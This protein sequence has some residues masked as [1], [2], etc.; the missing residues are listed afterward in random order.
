[1]QTP[2]HVE[3]LIGL[4]LLEI[5]TDVEKASHYI[6]LAEKFSDHPWVK[7]AR[8]KLLSKIGKIK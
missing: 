8:G 3:S 5:D 6:D 4:A 2:Y 7:F 1:M